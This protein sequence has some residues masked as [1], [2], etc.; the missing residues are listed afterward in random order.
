MHLTQNLFFPLFFFLQYNSGFTLPWWRQISVALAQQIQQLFLA[1]SMCAAGKYLRA[2][3][4]WVALKTV[5]S[6]IT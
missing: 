4:Y 5:R 6:L 3:L 2:A 1:A